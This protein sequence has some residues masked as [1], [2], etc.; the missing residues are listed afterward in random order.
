M[1]LAGAFIAVLL[2][3][4]Y[5]PVLVVSGPDALYA[6][7]AIE[8]NL[9]GS[10]QLLLE[11]FTR[12]MTGV[13]RRWSYGQPTLL[14]VLLLGGCAASVF[15]RGLGISAGRLLFATL[16]GVLGMLLLT[17][18]LPPPWI[19][20]F[21]LPIYAA[22]GCTGLAGIARR[23]PQGPLPVWGPRAVVVA[24]ALGIALAN[25][26]VLARTERSTSDPWYLGYTDAAE[27]AA[28]L[29]DVMQPADR[30][31][32][33]A[34][35]APPVLFYM[36][37]YG[38]RQPWVLTHSEEQT[39]GAIYLV[40]PE[41]SGASSRWPEHVP[42]LAFRE[43]QVVLELPRSRIVRLAHLPGERPDA[44]GGAVDSGDASDR[45]APTEPEG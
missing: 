28:Y 39:K 5:S 40:L 18:A 12:Q 10:K 36:R 34:V 7:R 24:A 6:N 1:I 13:W 33:H 29:L 31:A 27:A 26:S 14:Q 41:E 32:A 2:L 42:E 16:S 44:T 20:P 22:L 21:L 17:R 43:D 38:A 9:I 37:R 19:F 30:F 25:V 11:R 8:A 45:D 15:A 35:V 23:I 3:V 4:F